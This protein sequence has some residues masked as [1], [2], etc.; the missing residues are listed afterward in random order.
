MSSPECTMAEDI[1]ILR[2]SHWLDILQEGDRFSFPLSQTEWSLGPILTEKVLHG[3][4]VGSLEVSEASGVCI[5]TQTK[6]PSE[7]MKAILKIR[8]Q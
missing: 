4:R 3:D 6:G 2:E 8:M 1:G 7:G 5:A